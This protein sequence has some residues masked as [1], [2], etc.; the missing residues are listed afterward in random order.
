MNLTLCPMTDPQLPP[1][2]IHSDALGECGRRDLR[3]GEKQ[4]KQQLLLGYF[5]IQNSAQIR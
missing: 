5:Q 1:A 2:Y 4:Y 3:G